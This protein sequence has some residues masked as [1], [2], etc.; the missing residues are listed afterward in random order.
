MPS[1]LELQQAM[2]RSLVGGD[3]AA[4]AAHVVANGLA[5]GA[6][7][8]VYRNTALV[9]LTTALRLC[10]P[11][12][13]RLVGDEFFDGA[14]MLFIAAQPPQSAYLDA[15]GEAFAEFL[16]DFPPAASL[17]YLPGVA[18]LEWA[19]NR[20][21]HAPDIAP[22]DLLR[23]AAIDPANHPQV[24]LTPHPAVGLVHDAAPVDAIWR[25]VLA[26]DD[27]A[28]AAI[29]LDAGPVWLLVERGR[30][31]IEVERIEAEAWQF[32]AAL[33]AGRSIDDAVAAFPGAEPVQLIAGHL[34]AERF[35]GF[36]HAIPRRL[37]AASPEPQS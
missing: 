30:L 15:Y 8:Q 20:A 16:A 31:G 21:L 25:A 35:I 11:A 4:A 19:V 28:M 18:R 2:Y 29:D 33:F 32:T 22:L 24:V 14:A 27:A 6:R 7:L 17:R 23:L 9:T 36:E 12:V 3:D 34:A 37:R 26:Q 5:P 1:L 10:Y 13:Q